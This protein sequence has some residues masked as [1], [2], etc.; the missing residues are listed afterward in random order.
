M[1][2]WFAPAVVMGLGFVAA[3][4]MAQTYPAKTVRIIVPFPPVGAAD[5]LSRTLAQKLTEAWGQTVIVDNRPG[6][7]GNFGVEMA[8]KSAPD[9]YTTV[10]AAVT[11]NAIGMATYTKLGYDLERDLAPVVLA[12]NVPHILVI[13]PSLPAKNVKEVVALGRARP[14]ELAFAS[15][16]QGTL[17]HLEQEMLKQMGGFTALHVPYKGSAP[18]LSDLIPGNVQLFFDSIPSSLPHVKSGRLRAIGVAS[19]KRS[20]VLPEVPA[21][22]ESLKGFEADSWFGIMVPVGTPREIIVKFN[23]EAQ[24][25]L[26]TQDVKDRLLSQ[27]GV[28]GGGPPEA[29]AERVKADIAK[30][31]KV[32]RTAGVK[33]E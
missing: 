14:G 19:S 16:G 11:T 21:I 29:L 32:V 7:G 26:A 31:G 5:L 28:A 2:K 25:A 22:N 18:G 1:S 9:G 8:A 13:H 30:W 20:P 4:A 17:S 10:M 15:Q 27:G 6:V 23:A 33:I 3:G 12:G 24:K